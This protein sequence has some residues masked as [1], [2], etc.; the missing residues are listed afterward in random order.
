VLG[1]VFFLG[2]PGFDLL[3][4]GL[5]GGTVA[6]LAGERAMAAAGPAGGDL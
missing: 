5:V 3:L 4:T 2:A 6:Y 1:P